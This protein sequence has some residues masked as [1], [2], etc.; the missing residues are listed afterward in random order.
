M[1][2]HRSTGNVEVDLTRHPLPDQGSLE[3]RLGAGSVDLAVPRDASVTIDTRVTAGT[4]RVDG[5]TVD[6]GVDLGGRADRRERPWSS[7]STWPRGRWRSVMHEH[8]RWIWFAVLGLSFSLL[9]IALTVQE[10]VGSLAIRWDV[11][12][13]GLLVLAGLLVVGA[14]AVAGRRRTSS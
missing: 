11:L 14:A 2:V 1:T 12:L 7:P 10:V 3:I 9:G 8:Y 5:T 6:D 4:I 13:P